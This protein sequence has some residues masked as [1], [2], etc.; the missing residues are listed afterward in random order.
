MLASQRVLPR[1][2][3]AAGFRFQHP[4]VAEALRTVV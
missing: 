4:E 3:E 2:A 1:A